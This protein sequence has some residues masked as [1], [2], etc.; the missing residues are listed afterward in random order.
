M[1]RRRI[2]PGQHHLQPHT[3]NPEQLSWLLSDSNLAT[4][5]FLSHKSDCITLPLFFIHFI[6]YLFIFGRASHAACGSWAPQPGLEPGST[7]VKAHVLTTGL[8]G[9]PPTLPLKR[10]TSFLNTLARYRT[11]LSHTRAASYTWPPSTWNTASLAG[12]V[13]YISDSKT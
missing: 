3:T 4:V 11:V 7:A 10:I 6:I 12:S 1:P 5:V 13:T 2:S 9:N 8:P